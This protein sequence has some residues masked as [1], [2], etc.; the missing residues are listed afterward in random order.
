MSKRYFCIC[1]TFTGYG[2]MYWIHLK[3]EECIM[4]YLVLD[5]TL[6]EGGK[7]MGEEDTGSCS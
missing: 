4:A 2:S 5:Y 3:V 1:I 7:G 6:M